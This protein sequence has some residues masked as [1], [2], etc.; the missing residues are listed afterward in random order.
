MRHPFLLLVACLLLPA[1]RCWAADAPWYEDRKDLLWY[2]DDR[3]QLQPVKGEQD[4]AKRVAHIRAGMELVMGRLPEKASL[5]LDVKTGEAVGLQHYTRQHV[6]FVVEK[7]DRLPGW[8]LVPHGAS[9]KN[10]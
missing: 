1:D 9:E 7:G 2:K 8:L 6:S 4:W 3:R 5:P 10:R